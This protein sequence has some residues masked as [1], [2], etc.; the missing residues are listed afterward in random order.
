[1]RGGGGG[2]LDGLLTICRLWVISRFRRV[3]SNAAVGPLDVR[4]IVSAA[5]SPFPLHCL[6]RQNMF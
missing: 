3:D 4:G 2:E 1:M 6:C 5:L